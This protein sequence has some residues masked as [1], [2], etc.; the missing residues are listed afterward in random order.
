MVETSTE[1]V[2]CFND[3]SKW[4]SDNEKLESDTHMGTT[5]Y[6]DQTQAP[7]QST[8]REAS[9]EEC[10]NLNSYIHESLNAWQGFI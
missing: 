9:P 5:E 7:C 8:R 4:Q 10:S 6:Q 2:S 1:Y 3:R